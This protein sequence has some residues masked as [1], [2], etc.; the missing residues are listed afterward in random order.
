MQTILCKLYSVQKLFYASLFCA[1]LFCEL[2]DKNVLE[3]KTK[4]RK[5]SIRRLFINNFSTDG[6]IYCY[7]TQFIFISELHI[8]SKVSDIEIVSIIGSNL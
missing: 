3:N 4:I 7:T 1:E 8:I 5:H 2:K 6:Q